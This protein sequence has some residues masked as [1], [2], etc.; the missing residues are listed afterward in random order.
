VC[1]AHMEKSVELQGES[2]RHWPYHMAACFPALEPGLPG[3]KRRPR[4]LP[5]ITY[6]VAP[7]VV[8]GMGT[9]QV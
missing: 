7:S 9:W 4:S 8:H 2:P 5:L 1:V 6:P 3:K